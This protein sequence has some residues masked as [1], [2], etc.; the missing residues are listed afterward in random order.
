MDPGSVGVMGSAF[1]K[2]GVIVFAFIIAAY[3]FYRV[4]SMWFEKSVD[5][6]EAGIYLGLLLF[7][8][9]GIVASWGTIVGLLLLLSLVIACLGL[10]LLNRI[11]EKVALRRMEDDD[12][13]SFTQS[14]KEQPKNTYARE[15]LARIFLGR[16]EYDL[17]L[18]QVD[19]ALEVQPRDRTF[20]RLR[21]RIETDQRRAVHHLKV[22][23][24][25]VT[26]NPPDAGACL[27]CG[28]MFVDPGDLLRVLWSEPALQAARWGGLGMII[29]GAIMLM[30]DL[31]PALVT[32][33]MLLGLASIFWY[34]YVHFSRV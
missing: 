29:F 18:Y 10:P 28:F 17:A 31:N 12:V 23:P 25:C 20:E 32:L 24:K 22:C 19:Q 30:L 14:L 21:D 11:S 2:G 8:L 9:L 34:M 5:G 1:F 4:L 15:R 26:E 3:P 6:S 7:L 16:R 33:V 27:R 13:L